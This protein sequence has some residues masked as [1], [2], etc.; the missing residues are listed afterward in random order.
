MLPLRQEAPRLRPWRRP[1]SL[2][3]LGFRLLEGRTGR[4]HA[5][6]G[7]P[8][9]RGRGRDGAVVYCFNVC[10]AG[11]AVFFRMDYFATMIYLTC[12]KLDLKAVTAA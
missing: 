6:S 7:P 4:R 9:V 1:S 5:A 3:S 11:S 12:G 8:P 2:A 10:W